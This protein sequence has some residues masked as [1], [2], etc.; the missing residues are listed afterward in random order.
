MLARVPSEDASSSTV[1]ERTRFMRFTRAAVS[2][3]SDQATA[4]QL[5]AELQHS[6]RE[7]RQLALQ[8]AGIFNSSSLSAEGC[9]AMKAAL[10]IPWHRLRHIRR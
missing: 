1:A 3:R 9:L 2:G 10:A 5:A 7:Q 8:E 4:T 6:S